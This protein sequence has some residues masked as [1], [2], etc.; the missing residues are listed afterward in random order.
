MAR[1]LA[2]SRAGRDGPF[3]LF[4]F[5]LLVGSAGFAYRLLSGLDF[6]ELMHLFQDD[7]YYYF[8]IARNLAA[9]Q[10]STFDGGITVTN[11]YQP[12]W[13]FLITPLYWIFDAEAALVAIKAFEFALL[14]GGVALVA[15]AARLARLPWILLAFVPLALS[16]HGGLIEGMEAALRLF[17]LGLLFAFLGAYA[18]NPERWKWPLAGIAFALPWVRLE[19]LAVALVATGTLFLLELRSF[20]GGGRGSAW[21]QERV[22]SW[23]ALPALGPL[24]AAA[25]S[26]PAYF[27]YNSLVFGG[28]VPV[29]G[30]VKRMWSQ[31]KW[32]RDGGYSFAQSFQ[33]T[34]GFEAFDGELLAAFEIC[35]Y[36]LI[37]LW[38]GRSRT[39]WFATVFLVGAFSLA[40]S[41]LA[42]FWH[43][44]FNMH[45]S[46]LGWPW[47][48]VP[49]RLMMAILIPVRCY[50]G[51]CL[52]RKFVV[53]RLPRMAG[54]LAI[55]GVIGLG[56]GMQALSG[57]ARVVASES[58]KSPLKVMDRLSSKSFSRYLQECYLNAQIMNRI[59][60]SGSVV[61]VWN[62]G[63]IGYYSEHPVV[64]LDGLAASYDFFADLRSI[65]FGF[66]YALNAPE[67]YGIFSKYG[68]THFADL[69]MPLGLENDLNQRSTLLFEGRL[70]R[71]VSFKIFSAEPEPSI[72][73]LADRSDYFFENM[74]PFWHYHSEGISAVVE[75]RIVRAF[76]K[77]CKPED[78]QNDWLQIL[79]QGEQPDPM[80]TFWQPW[81]DV[82]KN[83]LGF[84]ESTYNLPKGAGEPIRIQAARS[85]DVSL[86]K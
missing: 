79:W 30:A 26:L 57:S 37:L 8:E 74:K 45:F 59:L 84:C 34:V 85:D 20:R 83:S 82:K 72:S 32:V 51:I 22:A 6:L 50:V 78:L 66:K 29:S 53:P 28:P 63:L 64:N 10:F 27:A 44:V 15:V 58:P 18:R 7:A 39:D 55:L 67:Y 4:L 33:E 71:Y 40:V 43:F 68:I 42:T 16:R 17:A 54:Q 65:R 11:G 5:G 56:L 31:Y 9:G 46:E 52:L 80:V 19:D 2:R 12:V 49:A 14:A 75:R 23:T 69:A 73:K 77:N 21:L 70:S 62:A 25:A 60:P 47:Y 35:A 24:L 3:V 1:G 48:F 86:M 76:A 41:H 13:L 81:K 38:I 61:G 36:L